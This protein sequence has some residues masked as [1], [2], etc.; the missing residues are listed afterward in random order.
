MPS[1]KAKK[2]QC[3]RRFSSKHRDI[4]AYCHRGEVVWHNANDPDLKSP[5]EKPVPPRDW[6]PMTDAE[7]I[8]QLTSFVKTTIDLGES[9]RP[10][11]YRPG[12]PGFDE[13]ARLYA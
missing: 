1:L 12:T 7:V 5:Y 4:C 13:L 6:Q 3:G 2:C 11:V 10:I 8:S 9:S